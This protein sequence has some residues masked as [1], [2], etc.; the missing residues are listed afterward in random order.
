MADIQTGEAAR[1]LGTSTQTVGKLIAQNKLKARQHYVG[2]KRFV[3]L[4]D[5]TSI[6][7]HLRE[8]GRY[9]KPKRRTLQGRV[10]R[11]ESELASLRDA[12]KTAG[13]DADAKPLGAT[14]PGVE[15]ERDEL[16][17]EVSTLRDALARTRDVAE[18]QRLADTER[19]S[20]IEHLTGAAAASERAD[21]HRRRAMTEL[22]EALAGAIG[23]RHPGDLT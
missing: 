1:R 7:R 5:E 3:W 23:P 14:D 11:I 22:E 13:V 2:N 9:D 16:R 20:V 21:A 6:E 12:L 17:A 8:H 18:L 15:R 4:V 19:A 10:E